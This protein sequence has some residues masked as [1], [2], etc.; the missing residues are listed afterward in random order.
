MVVLIAVLFLFWAALA[1]LLTAWSVWFQG[2]LYTEPSTGII[3]RGPAAAGVI[4]F[5]LLIWVVC[6]YRSVNVET[7]QGRYRT[8]FDF[9]STEESDRYA[10]LRVPITGGEDVYKLRQ[11]GHEYRRNGDPKGTLLTTPEKIIAVEKNGDRSTF[12]PERDAQGKFLRRRGSEPLRYIDEKGRV[13]T[14]GNLGQ[15]TTFYFG[16]FV[17]NLLLNLLFFAALFLTMWLLIRFQWAHA[18]G[19]AIV[20][21]IAL[22]L[23]VVPTI[24]SLAERV[25]KERAVTKTALLFPFPRGRGE[26][27]GRLIATR[28]SPPAQW[29]PCGRHP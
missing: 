15:I 16:V 9:S 6:D 21:W 22:E 2:F 1:A 17:G 27:E 23:V 13:M 14:E 26:E 28:P 4:T 25:S 29:E 18:L 11:T 20:L 3:W 24:L 19:Q 5:W 10:E 7:G 8:L 12:E